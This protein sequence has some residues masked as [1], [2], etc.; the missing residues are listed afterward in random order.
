[1]NTAVFSVVNAVLLRPLP[2]PDAGR[3]VWLAEG[4]KRV[5]FEAVR[6]ADY[7]EWK[8]RSH[9]FEQMVPYGYF[10][11][12]I[13]FGSDARQV[14]GI[15]SSDE[16]LAITGAR[17]EKGTPLHRGRP[18]RYSDHSQTMGT[19]FRQRS[20][21]RRQADRIRRSSIHHLRGAPR[22]LSLCAAA[23]G[24]GSRYS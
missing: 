4:G 15:A 10:S 21:Y 9:S 19:S 24:S 18:Q 2:Y 3:L 16:F 23:G 7:F 17:P 8:A 22:E 14:G 13:Y 20:G 6:A 12:P 1:M 11:A 5:K